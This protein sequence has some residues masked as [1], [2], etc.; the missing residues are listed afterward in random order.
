MPMN[1]YVCMYIATQTSIVISP[2]LSIV[3]K[4]YSSEDNLSLIFWKMQ[5]ST[6]EPVCFGDKCQSWG[7]EAE[8]DSCSPKQDKKK[9]KNHRK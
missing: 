4:T 3:E 7:K 9:K 8:D 6:R 2:A 5:L 1:M